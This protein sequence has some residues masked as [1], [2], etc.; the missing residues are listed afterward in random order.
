M[1]MTFDALVSPMLKTDQIGIYKIQQVDEV[2]E[3]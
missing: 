3:L 1:F 2:Y